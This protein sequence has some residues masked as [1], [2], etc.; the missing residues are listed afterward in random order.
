[1]AADLGKRLLAEVEEAGLD[2][3]CHVPTSSDS[4]QM[5]VKTD[6]SPRYCKP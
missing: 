1:M 4:E 6:I 5:E 2:E 3:V